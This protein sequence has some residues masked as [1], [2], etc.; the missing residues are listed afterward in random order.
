MRFSS[1]AKSFFVFFAFF[2]AAVG[3]IMAADDASI[4]LPSPDKTISVVITAAGKLKYSLCVD[5]KPVLSESKLG[6]QFRNGL[7]FGQN[8]EV[9]KAERKSVDSTWEN[10]FGKRRQVRNNYN[11]LRLILREKSTS[12]N[13]FEVVFRAFDD[14]VGFRYV[15]PKQD[16]LEQFVLTKELTEFA[17]AENYSCF[18]GKQDQG[19]QGP[20]E[21]EFKPGKLSDLKAKSI[22]GLPLLVQTPTAWVAVLEADL[23][24]WSGMWLAGADDKNEIAKNGVTVGVKLAP[25]R[26]GQGLVK[27]QAP[28]ASPWRTLMIGRQPGRL[29]ESDLV[30]NLSEPC[31]LKDVSWIRPGKMAWDHWWSGDVKMDTATLKQYIQLA[32]DMGWPYQLIDWQWYGDYNKPNSDITKVNPDV[33]MDEVRRFAAEKGVKLWVWLYWTDVDRNDAYIKAFDLYKQWGIVGV[34]IDFMDRDDQEMVDWYE[35]ITLAAAERQLMVN[36]HGAFKTSGF[37]RT[38]PNQITR[39]GVLGNEYNRFS[40]SVTPAHKVMLPFTRYLAGPADFTPGGFLNRQPEKFKVDV[41]AAQT[42]GTRAA[43]LAL[44]V[45]YDS[46]ICC[47]CDHPSHYRNQP[48]V[49]FLKVVPTVWDDTRVLEAEVGKYLVLAR[50]SGN[51]WYIGALTDGNA[52]DFEVKLNFLGEKSR[53]ARIWKDAADSQT[54]PERLETEDRDVSASDI[55]KLHLASGGGCVARIQ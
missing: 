54:A 36:F 41:K 16:G 51:E 43:E 42:Q 1:F 13:L 3:S 39:E 7:T 26:D 32:A 55:L 48:G 30:A 23:C 18:V 21:W 53:K 17:F 22:V 29:V 45:L 20:Q 35:K 28:Q 9:V 40:K 14:G 37:N 15:L 19:F 6:L 8:V 11:E 5:G 33:D 25:R 34:K 52:R 44:F 49:D 10:L 38:Y 12:P 46:P 31:K 50:R 4:E 47:V 27:A 24:D 2:C